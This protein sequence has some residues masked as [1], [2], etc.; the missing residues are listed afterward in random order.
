MVGKPR[1]TPSG[2][3]STRDLLGEAF[4]HTHQPGAKFARM[5]KTSPS[6]AMVPISSPA[7]SR[8]L[9]PNAGARPF[10]SRIVSSSWRASVAMIP[11]RD[12]AAARQPQIE[13]RRFEAHVQRQAAHKRW[14]CWS[15]ARNVDSRHCHQRR[16]IA[17]V[18]QYRL[19]GG[20]SSVSSLPH[21]PWQ[22]F[23]TPASAAGSPMI[24]SK[25]F[26]DQAPAST[27]EK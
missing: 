3:P 2:R 17:P 4:M 7:S 16:R 21:V 19:S 22:Y 5:G 11:L 24:A 6:P 15:I 14:S 26:F 13:R 10:A 23:L 9:V 8:T 20:H 18:A 27:S 1:R 25:N 12:D